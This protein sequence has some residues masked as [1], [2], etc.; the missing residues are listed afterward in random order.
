MGN[1]ILNGF[2]YEGQD[3]TE[4]PYRRLTNPAQPLNINQF[5]PDAK[6]KI[7]KF[8]NISFKDYPYFQPIEFVP[9]QSYGFYYDYPET[10]YARVRL[11]DNETEA[12]V[13][14]CLREWMDEII[15]N[16]R[17]CNDYCNSFEKDIYKTVTKSENP[18]IVILRQYQKIKNNQ[19]PID[20][21]IES[22]TI[23]ENDWYL[24]NC[25]K[26]IKVSDTISDELLKNRFSKCFRNLEKEVEII[27]PLLIITADN[28]SYQHLNS[29]YEIIQSS[30]L[31]YD[32]IT[33]NNSA[34]PLINFVTLKETDSTTWDDLTL[35]L[36]IL[37]SVERVSTERPRIKDK[38]GKD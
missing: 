34:I 1:S 7:F 17:R 9:S 15:R 24:T 10:G 3:W 11:S 31:L 23:N 2:Q 35:V 13:A 32:I 38:K 16:C 21:I 30:T 33:I 22:L 20:E 18:K 25:I 27:Q 6:D 26:C 12:Y 37:L 14:L 28:E 4:S 36:K 19:E 8:E 5:A 29:Q